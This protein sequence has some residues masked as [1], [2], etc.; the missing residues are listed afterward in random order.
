MGSALAPALAGAGHAVTRLVRRTAGAG[1]IFWDPEKSL[2]QG[3][4]EGFDAVIHLAGESIA[5]GRW[6]EARMGRIRGSR[7]EGTRFLAE[8]L[9][10]L[11]SPPRV[12]VSA[13]AIGYYGDRGEESLFETSGPGT[14]FLSSVCA[15]WE[16]A[17]APASAKGVR[18]VHPR[19]GVILSRKGGALAKMLP[20]FKMGFGG[21]LGSGRQYMSWITLQDAVGVILHALS[22]EG[23]RG[24]VNAVSPAPVSNAEFTKVLAKVLRRPAV[25]P[26]PAF[27]ARILFGQMADEL[28]LAG[29]RV[30]PEALRRSGYAF[31]NPSLEEGLRDVLS[32]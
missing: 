32:L 8:S 1:E 2:L 30:L 13:S 10:K 5:S 14:N 6:T 25:F 27:A 12:L 26:M 15:A 3:S 20:P 16:A 29:A 23:V 28:L 7:V 9:A 24:P 19:F 21:P 17:C 22:R 4:L 31:K 18:V 11:G